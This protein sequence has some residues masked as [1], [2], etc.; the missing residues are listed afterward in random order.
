MTLANRSIKEGAKATPDQVGKVLTEIAAKKKA[1]IHKE[2]VPQKIYV[3]PNLLGLSRYTVVESNITPHIEN[4]IKECPEI[5]KLIVPITK[6]A[7]TEGRIKE[8]GTLE[9]RHYNN[10]LKYL[11][12][13]GD[14]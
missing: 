11:N 13:K 14:E 10:V 9:H 2:P 3:G 5:E 6:M 4:L 7:E 1:P 12:R 8:K